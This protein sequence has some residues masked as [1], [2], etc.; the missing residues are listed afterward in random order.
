M[1]DVLPGRG[2]DIENENEQDLLRVIGCQGC[3]KLSSQ[4]FQGLGNYGGV[5]EDGHKVGVAEPAWDDVDVK[6]FQN[7]SAGDFAEI[8]ADVEPFRFHDFGEGILAATSEFEEI[9]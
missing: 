9:G 3:S 2:I 6:V 4:I 1:L 5:G 8:D 7:S